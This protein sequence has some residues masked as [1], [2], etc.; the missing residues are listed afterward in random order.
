MVFICHLADR[1]GGS[2]QVTRNIQADHHVYPVVGRD[3]GV[4]SHHLRQVLRGDVQLVGIIGQLAVFPVITVVQH[5]DEPPHYVGALQR[6]HPLAIDSLLNVVYIVIKSLQN[7][8]H[9]Q[10]LY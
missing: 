1:Q 8:Y 10:V 3:A 7:H 9:T 2:A 6:H 5:V 4:L